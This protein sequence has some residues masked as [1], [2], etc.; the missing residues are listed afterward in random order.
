MTTPKQITAKIW[1][2]FHT[3]N[4][5]DQQ[6]RTDSVQ[7]LHQ[8]AVAATQ[9]LAMMEHIAPEETHSLLRAS[10]SWP[11]LI[12]PTNDSQAMHQLDAI[13]SHLGKD[14]EFNQIAARRLDSNAAL[15]AQW[16]YVLE[17]ERRDHLW[18]NLSD[19]CKAP[20][21]RAAKDGQ[22]PEECFSEFKSVVYPQR[23][24][25]LSLIPGQDLRWIYA[26]GLLEPLTK[27]NAAEWAEAATLYLESI[28]PERN[29]TR[30]PFAFSI[31]IDPQLEE[32]NPEACKAEF[33]HALKRKLRHGFEAIAWNS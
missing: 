10:T 25:Q 8:I 11:L 22:T 15:A 6:F 29:L 19:Y 27:K 33:R 26:A 7:G 16:Y 31:A 12:A 18:E 3:A 4:G 28:S 14:T 9:A 17:S 23:E 20:Y 2:I 13:L 24:T 30:C 1:N 21:A 5:K 32:A